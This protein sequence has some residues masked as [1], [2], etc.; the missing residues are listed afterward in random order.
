M[1]RLDLHECKVKNKISKLRQAIPQFCA[2]GAE[3]LLL[4]TLGSTIGFSSILIPELTKDKTDIFLDRDDESW[5]SSMNLFTAPF[6][7]LL[8]GLASTYFGRKTTMQLA[9]FPYILSWLIF[10]LSTTKQML[11]IALVLA[12]LNNGIVEASVL[13]YVAEVSQPHLRGILSSTLSVAVILGFLTQS[14]TT[15]LTNWR[16][17][18]LVNITYPVIG[19]IAFC[20]VPESPYW[21]AEKQQIV[22]AEKA[23]CWLRGWVSSCQIKNELEI[24]CISVKP[25]DNKHKNKKHWKEFTKQTFISPFILV[26][27]CFVI[28]NFAGSVCIQTY[29]VEIFKEL[30]T[31]IGIKIAP[32]YLILAQLIGTIIC[33]VSIF[34]TGKRTINFIS[35]AGGGLCSLGISIYI[36]L[37]EF[38]FIHE[39]KYTWL[40]SLLLIGTAFISHIGIRLL[41]WIIVGEVFP[42]KVKSIATSV[43]VAINY[44]FSGIANKTYL[45]LKDIIGLSGTFMLYAIIYFIGLVALYFMLPETEGKTLQE[46]QQHYSGIHKLNKNQQKEQK[47]L[48]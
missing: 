33:V 21:L 27:V 15:T 1:E 8:S 7:C 22:N 37:V 32:V 38:N 41:V 17:T 39:N 3:N 46:I 11:F 31:P 4:V 12:G 45:G 13:T 14:L 48:I 35:I 18:C 25:K 19:F 6:G 23:L 2:V 40:P 26:I 42:S 16:T 10:Y 29:S 9:M 36:Y 44:A 20:L 34:F 28:V 5:I 30:N 47:I 24:I 43:S